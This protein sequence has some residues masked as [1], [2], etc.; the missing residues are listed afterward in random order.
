[1]RGDHTETAGAGGA[2]ED[3]VAAGPHQEPI[4]RIEPG[5]HAAP[6]KRLCCD[7]S[8]RLLATA[9]DDRTVRLWALPEGRLLRILRPPIGGGDEGKILA[10]AMAPAGDTL[11][12][13]GW[14]GPEWDGA[15]C[16]YRFDPATGAITGR[17]TGLPNIITHLAWSPDGSRLAATLGGQGGVRVWRTADW[18]LLFADDSYRGDSYGADFDRHNMLAT[19][20]YDGCV[21]LYD[22]TGRCFARAEMAR[23]GQPFGVAFAPEGDRLAVG[24]TGAPTVSVFGTN[25]LVE[26]YRADARDS[27][28]E[29]YASVAWSADGAFLY[30]G[31]RHT[32]RR[33]VYAVR[34]WADGGRG[35]YIDLPAAGNTI[36]HLRPYGTAGVLYGA[37]GPAFGAFDGEGEPIVQVGPATPDLRGAIGDLFTVSQDGASVRIAIDPDGPRCVRYDFGERRLQAEAPED[38]SL[39]RART[40]SRKLQIE[41]WQDTDAP[42]L[43]GAPL[44]I[45]RYEVSRSL[46]I[47]SD[48]SRF[49][50]G[51]DWYLRGFAADGRLL[52]R[53]ALPA[54]AWGVN[55]SGDDRFALAALDDGTVRWYRLTDGAEQAALFVTHD[56]RRWVAWTPEGFYDAS[57]GAESLIGWHV[58]R[59]TESAADFFPASCFRE[60]FYRPMELDRVFG[61]RRLAAQLRSMMPPVLTILSPRTGEAQPGGPV[62]V[63]FELRSP[64]GA[65]LTQIRVMVDET[66]LPGPPL[67]IP[68][69]D[70]RGVRNVTV[71]VPQGAAELAL[72]PETVNATGVAARL[73]FQGLVPFLGLPV[74]TG[75]PKPALYAL[76][77]GCN[78]FVGGEGTLQYAT[79]DAQDFADFFRRQVGGL[80]RDVQVQVHADGTV[81]RARIVRGME[82]LRR[83]P[84]MEDVAI[85]FMA[86]HGVNDVD[87]R[88]F[89]LPE[90]GDLLALRA[91]AVSEA[92]IVQL[93]GS[94]PGRRVAFLD[95]C[96]AGNMF[97]AFPQLPQVV[98]RAVVNLD[99]L[100]NELASAENGVI[101]FASSTGTQ[102]SFESA[103]WGNGAF[104]KALLEAL[105]GKADLN[106]DRG[107]S[108]NELSFYTAER[109]KELTGGIQSPNVLRPHSIRDFPIAVANPPLV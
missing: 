56:G 85:L 70:E 90:T 39:I 4:L 83:Q 38:D 18:T 62:T 27:R 55:I 3:S 80:Y 25:R 100:V 65:P 104:T 69:P 105:N 57:P 26:L 66:P 74:V 64:S 12:A 7:A 17:L 42:R 92:D 60:R 96:H 19:T 89:F 14:T 22:E 101:A 84:T 46:A 86:G 8:G 75:T 77:I 109:V 54:I 6:I 67:A 53:T 50:L 94:T 45:E 99:R 59:D 102:D 87:G 41:H 91:T 108:I 20:S 16:L 43:N 103:A 23:I 36:M 93:L 73:S 11:V 2:P 63:G 51:T 72:V 21:R 40:R 97:T 29:D 81:D 24:Y 76:C 44:A 49:I 79:K 68:E 82:W 52:W 13:G 31:G 107:I 71:E 15:Y 106:G 35:G 37:A 78:G 32:D 95:T 5:H 88:Y 98:P 1:M 47:A 9:S 10:V 48:N 61:H 33:G 58:N 28:D 30:G 34:R